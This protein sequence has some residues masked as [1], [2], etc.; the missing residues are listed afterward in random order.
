VLVVTI[1]VCCVLGKHSE[2]ILH[3]VL[4]TTTDAFGL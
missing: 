4:V 2:D 1:P 3:Q